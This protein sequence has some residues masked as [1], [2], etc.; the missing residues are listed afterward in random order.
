[1][2]VSKPRGVFSGLHPTSAAVAYLSG[3]ALPATDSPRPAR[4]REVLTVEAPVG[5]TDPATAVVTDFTWER[6]VIVAENRSIDD[7]MRE[8]MQRVVRALLVMQRES[9]TG[10]I[11]A[12]DIQ[13]ERPLKFLRAS[14][15]LRRSEI[16][17]GHIMT[18]WDRLATLDWQAVRSAR[19][20]AIVEAFRQTAATH[21]PVV[22][23]G[24]QG[25]AFVRGLISRARLERQL[26][27]PMGVT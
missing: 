8:M 17:V 9:V 21:L 2:L 10:L 3:S 1:M 16:H 18:P 6:P 27:Q 13:G 12:Y 25:G 23:H 19:L 14:G 4:H 22:E 24:E 11:T 15:L 7:A 5:L 20:L 26:G